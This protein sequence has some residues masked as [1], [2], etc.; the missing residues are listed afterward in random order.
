MAES[1]I[2]LRDKKQRRGK[3]IT[4]TNDNFPKSPLPHHDALVILM[5]IGNVIVY[6]ILVDMGSSVNV[7]YYDVFTKLTLIGSQ[8]N[9]VKTPLSRFTSDSMEIKG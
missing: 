6:R 2:S 1:L 4:F 9:Q 7:L 3:I 5:D 8:L